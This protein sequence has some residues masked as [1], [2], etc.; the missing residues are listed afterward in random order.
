MA[1]PGNATSTDD[2]SARAR[3]FEGRRALVTGASRGI[4]AGIAE[5]LAAQG[6][7][8]VITARTLD[9]HPTLPGSLRETAERL[10]RY[11]TRIGV[12]VADLAEGDDRSR[13]VPESTELLRG[14]IDILVNNAA[15]A[16]YAPTSEQPLR[17][18]RITFEVNVHAPVDLAQSV[19]PAMRDRGEGWI[20]NL[21][22]GS[23][24]HAQGP[25]FEPG[26]SVT[27]GI[28]GASKAALN[29]ESNALA[30]ELWNTGIRVNAVEPRAA[31][32]S[33]G[34]EVLAG[35][36]IT[37][38]QKESLEEMVEATVFL[39]DCGAEQTGGVHVSLD[40]IAAHA[41]RV[42]NLDGTDR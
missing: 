29:R 10:E 28:Y 6:A 39:C 37:E 17:R 8:V 30:Q 42:K 25:P 22:S 11:G 4:G 26:F 9:A 36:I 33:E 27:L 24:R 34:A 20:V 19:I 31:V 40:L 7:D 2:R 13:I 15:A 12:V 35:H 38:D 16:I 23:T 5:R 3:R 32:M 21:T 41:L 14:P 18:R 1:L